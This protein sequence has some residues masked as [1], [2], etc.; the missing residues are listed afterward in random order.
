MDKRVGFAAALLF[1][2]TVEAQLAPNLLNDTS[3]PVNYPARILKGGEQVCPAQDQLETATMLLMEELQALVLNISTPGLVL[4]CE[5]TRKLARA[6]RNNTKCTN[7]S[8]SIHLLNCFLKLLW[9]F[10]NPSYC[11]SD[12]IIFSYMLVLFSYSKSGRS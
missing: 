10:V 11:M 8:Y 12:L 3:L 1:C 9:V 2:I 6:C 4:P 7:C 5:L